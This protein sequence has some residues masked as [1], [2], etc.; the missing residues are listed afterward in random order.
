[1]LLRRL[2]A[3]LPLAT[4]FATSAAAQRI[5][6]DSMAGSWTL[7]SGPVSYRLMRRAEQVT[8]DYFGPTRGWAQRRTRRRSRC[9]L[10]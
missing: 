1:M 6:Y 4:I 10:T 9:A 3:A 8:F 2:L 7:T 5:A